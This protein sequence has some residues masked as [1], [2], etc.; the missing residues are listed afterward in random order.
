MEII[1]KLKYMYSAAKKASYIYN[2]LSQEAFKCYRLE[3]EIL[4][5]VH[6]IEKGLS[7]ENVRLG[8]GYT[9]IKETIS[10]IEQ[11]INK[12]G[13]VNAKP[14][15]MFADALQEY[16][17]FHQGKLTNENIQEISKLYKHLSSKITRSEHHIGGVQIIN[18]KTFNEKELEVIKSLFNKR[19]S[20]REFAQI[21]VDNKVLKEA[22]SLAMRCPNA[23][24]R[25]G[26]RC[27]VLPRTKKHLMSDWM[28]G[29]GGFADDVDKFII[30][31]GKISSYRKSEELQWA[32]TAT[33]FA[34]YLTLSLEA[35]GIGCCFI[36]RPIVPDQKWIEVA[37]R[38]NIS[39]DEQ[40]VCVLGIGNL[41]ES[42]KVPLSYRLPFETLVKYI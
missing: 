5:N 15:L 35:F 10:I 7:L 33:V 37:K 29:V 22:I 19:H 3:G 17:K 11:Y 28:E 6:S 4:R 42:Y 27:Y 31:T 20:V 1:K 12:G 9:K 30:I 23:C 39:K 18:K 26:Y 25:Q 21:P 8:F 40:I 2:I 13:D 36:Q 16:L 24:N 14:I 34:S 38:L 41:K 32:I